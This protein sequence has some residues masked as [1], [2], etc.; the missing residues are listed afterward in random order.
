MTVRVCA[1][2]TAASKAGA[3]PV[4]GIA[5]AARLFGTSKQQLSVVKAALHVW[6]AMVSFCRVA[7]AM[8]LLPR[9]AICVKGWSGITAA[10]RGWTRRMGCCAS[11]AG[12]IGVHMLLTMQDLAMLWGSGGAG[13]L[14]CPCTWIHGCMHTL[15][16]TLKVE[17]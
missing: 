1:A 8:Q 15:H 6:P 11:S 16:A 13:G 10:S 3:G 4:Q 5:E 12:G 9:M 14:Q 7:S 17:G 2:S